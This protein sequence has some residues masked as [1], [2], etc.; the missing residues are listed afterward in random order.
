MNVYIC[1]CPNPKGHFGYGHSDICYFPVPANEVAKRAINHLP[2]FDYLSCEEATCEA[3]VSALES[4]QPAPHPDAG[5]S[6]PIR[7]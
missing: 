6:E 7:D 2:R 1:D 4:F 3:V 5:Y